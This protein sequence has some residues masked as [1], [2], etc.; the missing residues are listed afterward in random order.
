MKSIRTKILTVGILGMLVLAI[1]IT[2]VSVVYIGQILDR[3]SDIITETVS[4]TEALKINE[5][6][7]HVVTSAQMME[8][9]IHHGARCRRG[10]PHSRSLPAYRFPSS[11]QR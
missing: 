7:G 11:V 2:T 1:A 6:L 4:D 9:Y 3:D 5:V 10:S 8:T